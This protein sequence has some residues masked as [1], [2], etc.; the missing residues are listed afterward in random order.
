MSKFTIKE[1]GI[2]DPEGKYNNPL[3]GNKYT[4]NYTR[5]SL[6]KDPKGWSLLRAY[7]DKFEILKKNT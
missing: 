2:L 4:K 1:N 7:H 5:I 6:N 3:T